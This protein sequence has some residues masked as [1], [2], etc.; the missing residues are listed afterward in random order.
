MV[1]RVRE[2]AIIANARQQ[3]LEGQGRVI[4]I[5]GDAGC[6]KS[7]LLHEALKRDPSDWLVLDGQALPYG[8]K[9]YRVILDMLGGCFSLELGDDMSE[10]IEKIR[11]GL[12]LH[13]QEALLGPLA[14]MHDLATGD[15]NWDGLSPIERGRRM[16]NAVCQ[17]FETISVARPLALVAEDMHWVDPESQEILARLITQSAGTRILLIMTF[18]PEY[19]PPSPQSE[20]HVSIRLDPH[21]VKQNHCCCWRSGWRAAAASMPWNR[22]WWHAPGA[23]RCSWKKSCRASP[24]KAYCGARESTFG[25]RARWSRSTCRSLYAVCCRSGSIDWRGRRR[26]SC[27]PPR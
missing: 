7:R 1:G 2:L 24:R 20:H 6:G 10:A 22:C 15:S 4:S 5:S 19:Q 12:R 23:I 13:D 27:K 11:T 26:T 3:V 25:C 9:G 8:N 21:E 14:A 17:L 16:Q 18:R